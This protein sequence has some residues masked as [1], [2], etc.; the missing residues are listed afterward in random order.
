MTTLNPDLAS[1]DVHYQVDPMYIPCDRR[2]PVGYTFAVRIL[3]PRFKSNGRWQ[4]SLQ[5]FKSREEADLAGFQAQQ[6][7]LRRAW[8]ML[9]GTEP[10]AA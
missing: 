10:A 9:G 8:T 2:H 7:T 4:D 3:S 1:L 6:A 5:W